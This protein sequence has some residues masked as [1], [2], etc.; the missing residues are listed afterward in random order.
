LLSQV[1]SAQT[2][3]DS[4]EAL[5]PHKKGI[6]K[7]DLLNEISFY[8]WNK[9]PQKGIEYA[10]NS[11]KIAI[12]N[13]YRNGEARAL[14]NIGV[15]YWAKGAFDTAITFSYRAMKIFEETGDKIGIKSSLNNIGI[16]YSAT[17]KLDKAIDYFTRSRQIA[18]ELNDFR[19]QVNNNNN[20][21]ETYIDL[22]KYEEALI[23]FAKNIEISKTN[24]VE[25]IIS[26][27][28]TNIG[29]CLMELNSPE[30]AINYFEKAY[31]IE[32]KMS[33]NHQASTS[34]NQIGLFYL[35]QKNLPQAFRYFKNA[36][37]LAEDAQALEQLKS[38]Q[39]NL[40]EYYIATNDLRKALDYKNKFI[41]TNDS[42]YNERSSMQIAEM[43]A[44]F[45]SEKKEKE[46]ELLRKDNDIQELEIEKQINLR[47]SFIGILFL[48]ILL[49]FI[50]INR[51]AIKKKANLV[52]SH[53]NNLI[54]NH[55]KELQLNNEKLEEQYQQ[56]KLL[57][58]TKDKF[59]TII[60]HDLKEPFN[61]ILGYAELLRLKFDTY[62]DSKKIQYITEINNSLKFVYKLIENLL[63]WAQTQTGKISIIKESLNLRE[64]VETGIDPYRLNASR[65]NI[66]IVIKVPVV[67]EMLIDKNTS[68]TFIGNIVNN[69]IKFTPEGGSISV[70]ANDRNDHVELH[71]I[72]TGVGMPQE[73]I[74]KLFRIDSSITTEGT[75]NEKG[76]GLGLVL[77]KEL[78]EKNGGTISVKSE[79]NKGSEFIVLL[80]KNG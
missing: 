43:R 36:E 76:T 49:V 16:I 13:K 59:F 73:I 15:H 66:N 77:C 17:N 51:F 23:Y 5:I 38:I 45:E 10:Q 8:Y 32:L 69:A 7:V 78:I 11:K 18:V 64:L 56:L 50:L 55:K 9:S 60:S 42:L 24:S 12:N 1:L 79:V 31:L 68:L 25:D 63:A 65:K 28:Y 3:I 26:S 75:N 46:N 2:N 34:A 21:G 14:L 61:S 29:I 35:K 58:A 44:Q 19:S 74:E 22:K 39:G 57:N 4:L 20:I 6:D 80:P 27:S 53:K 67:M 52:L 33:N 72:D 70:E 41:V 48:V 37:K 30:K 54:E 71:F 40:A 47:N 62:D